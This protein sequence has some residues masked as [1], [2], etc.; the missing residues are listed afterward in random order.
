MEIVK[1][2]SYFMSDFSLR[3][4][5]ASMRARVGRSADCRIAF[6]SLCIAQQRRGAMPWRQRFHFNSAPRLS[7]IWKQ[8]PN[9]ICWIDRQFVC[10]PRERTDTRERHSSRV[11]VPG[12]RVAHP[13]YGGSYPPVTLIWRASAGRLCRRSIMKSWPLGLREIASSIAACRRSLASDARSGLRRSAASSC[14]RHI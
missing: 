6:L 11:I 7:G 4:A 3:R 12:F 2:W 1:D 9:A 10:S 14:P 5:H 13:G 8:P